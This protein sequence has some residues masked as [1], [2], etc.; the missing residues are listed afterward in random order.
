MV[1]KEE[2]WLG[3]WVRVLRKLK[4]ADELSRARVVGLLG[5]K[6]QAREKTMNPIS[7]SLSKTALIRD[8]EE[9]A[10][11]SGPSNPSSQ[12]KPPMDRSN[13]KSQAVT[14]LLTPL[15]VSQVATRKLHNPWK[16]IKPIEE[17]TE[18]H[19]RGAL[20]YEPLFKNSWS[21]SILAAV[22]ARQQPIGGV[23]TEQLVGMVAKGVAI[24][25]IPQLS[26]RTLTKGVQ[27]LIDNGVAMEP[28]QRD[29]MQLVRSLNAVVGASRVEEV[30]F[31]NCPT[32]GC[33]ESQGVGII[34]YSLP[35][36]GT[37][38]LVLSDL[39]IGGPTLH[40]HRSSALEWTRL[41]RQLENQGS[42][43]IV[44]IPYPRSRWDKR[45]TQS[46]IHV[47][48]DRSTSLSRVLEIL[49]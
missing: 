15:A 47:P 25:R 48:W 41:A 26:V 45:L 40:G 5:F 6:W 20:P 44:L 4:P 9:V 30:H 27:L 14:D 38:V 29:L 34:P 39:G 10:S 17:V 3:D 23:D 43:L 1:N 35:G 42:S 21:R 19:L 7:P 11:Q 46:I 13:T 24:Q 32:R 18:R 37:P 49:R 33:F 22:V 8:K 28:F 36:P 31:S 2:I 12:D 16:A